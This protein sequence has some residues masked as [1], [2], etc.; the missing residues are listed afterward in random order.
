MENLIACNFVEMGIKCGEAVFVPLFTYQ[1]VIMTALGLGALMGFAF[2]IMFMADRDKQFK[3]KMRDL[4][5][6][7]IFE[8]LNQASEKWT[9]TDKQKW[10]QGKREYYANNTIKKMKHEVS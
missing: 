8:E 10:L 2:V 3:N 9:P 6:G 5:Y 1:I 7:Y 4:G